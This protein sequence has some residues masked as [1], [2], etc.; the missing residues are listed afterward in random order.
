MVG[1]TLADRLRANRARTFVGRVQ[2]TA[3]FRQALRS[4][5]PPFNLLWLH[6]PGGVGKSALVHRLADEAFDAGRCTVLVDAAGLDPTPDSLTRAVGPLPAHEGVVLL[7]DTAERLTPIDGWL[8]QEFLPALPADTLIVLAGRRPPNSR[9]RSDLGW[10]EQLR[11][12]ALRDLDPA[13]ARTYLIGRGIPAADLD[14]VLRRTHGH[15]LALALVSD[16][17]AQRAD[18][19]QPETGPV[20][21]Q[22]QDIVTVLLE[23]FLDDVPDPTHRRAL[24]VLGHARVTTAALLRATLGPDR[25]QEAFGWLQGLSFVELGAQGL[26]PHELARAVL[27]DDLRW[28]DHEAWQALHRQIRSCYVS[29][30]VGSTGVDQARATA[31]LLWFHRDSPALSAYTSWDTAFSLWSQPAAPEDLPAILDLV[32]EHEGQESVTL[33]RGWWQ[34]QPEAFHVIRR[35]PG[36]VHGFFVQLRLPADPGDDPGDDPVARAAQQLIARSA[37]L[38]PGEHARVLRSWIGRDGYHRP[39]PCHQMLAGVT[40]RTWLTEPGLAVS[41]AYATPP[42][43]WTP[44]F[45]Y[46]DYQRAPDGDVTVA[47]RDF[48]AYLHDWR[49]TPPT[50]WLELM[51]S[52]ERSAHG[53][54]SG[55]DDADVVQRHLRPQPLLVLSRE[56]FATAVKDAFRAANRPTELA[57]NPL[58][59]SRLVAD[60]A[61]AAPEAPATL[62]ELL[63]SEVTLLG[64]DGRRAAA[65]RALEVTYLT[66]A[67]TQEAAAAR[68]SLPFSTYR[69]HLGAGLAAVT[70]ALWARELGG[71]PP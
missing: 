45:A 5:P 29:R 20:S 24:Q 64:R 21:A 54:G 41:V 46:V 51:E 34:R 16:V 58:L 14:A 8:R 11:T 15:P 50:A 47:G 44:L 37:P 59:R 30:I 32:D 56:D 62:R 53:D 10:A 65:A 7:V 13:D 26:A 40:T 71:P 25:A 17:W 27:D 63:V 12:V 23:R 22:M 43:L 52:R 68:L 49:V 69:R 6:G 28:R 55:G 19:E 35:E 66:P 39:S 70:D 61:P 18:R 36:A 60:E 57:T 4:D 38:R 48:A 42:Q 9:W 33:H 2:E 1:P 3:L 31:D 67:R